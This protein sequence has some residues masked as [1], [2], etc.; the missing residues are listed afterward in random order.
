MSTLHA[1]LCEVLLSLPKEIESLKEVQQVLDL[2]E[3]K[4]VKP[5]DTRLCSSTGSKFSKC[6]SV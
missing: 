5:S 4:I 1:P 2:P 3:L 6:P